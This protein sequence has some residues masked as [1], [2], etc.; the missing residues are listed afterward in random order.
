MENVSRA[1]PKEY[2]GEWH[3]GEF[4][5]GMEQS[6]QVFLKLELEG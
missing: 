3:Y 5:I 1:G 2:R 6:A 4:F